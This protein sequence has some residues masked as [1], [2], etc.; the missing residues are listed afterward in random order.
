MSMEHRL[1]DKQT[2]FAFET[3]TVGAAAI[4][5][6]VATIYPADGFEATYGLF[7]VET[8]T[9]RFRMDGTAPTASVGHPLAADQNLEVHGKENL[10]NLKF[11]QVSGG[12]TVSC[13]Y[14]R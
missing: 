9:V 5:P 6:T 3:L 13:T 12:A 8:N 7:S 4:G 10:R 14:M 2:A 11:I 1:S